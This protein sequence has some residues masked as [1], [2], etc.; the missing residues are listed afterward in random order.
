M[1]NEFHNAIRK[2]VDTEKKFALTSDGLFLYKIEPDEIY[3]HTLISQRIYGSRVYHDVV[4]VCLG[5]SFPYEPAP[6]GA[7]YF[8][9]L[10]QLLAIRKKYE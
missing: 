4:R 2:Y 1:I 9:T 3:D 8:P 6:I 5:L 7:Y 10:K